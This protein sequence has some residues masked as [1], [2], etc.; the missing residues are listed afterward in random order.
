MVLL[1]S[2]ESCGG[3]LLTIASFVTD[4]LFPFHSQLNTYSDY[5]QC[6]WLARDIKLVQC[7]A[8]P[9]LGT[10]NSQIQREGLAS[11]YSLQLRQTQGYKQGW[12][13][14]QFSPVTVNLGHKWIERL[15]DLAEA[16][17]VQTEPQVHL[18]WSPYSKGAEGKLPCDHGLWVLR[19][20]SRQALKSLTWW[21][22]FP[23]T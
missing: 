6:W 14:I 18:E 21:V 10:N 17:M 1:L 23:G 16:Q 9:S 22:W 3:I 2:L 15:S 11:G 12:F 5:L 13:P 8:S 4:F 7:K 19:H 20:S